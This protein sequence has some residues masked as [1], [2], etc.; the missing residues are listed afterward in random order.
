MTT[1]E[2]G[3]KNWGNDGVNGVAKWSGSDNDYKD[4]NNNKGMM[5]S[6]PHQRQQRM[7][8]VDAMVNPVVD[9]LRSNF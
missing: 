6:M 1:A 2:R 3:G 8:V 5:A 7:G 9:V 4:N